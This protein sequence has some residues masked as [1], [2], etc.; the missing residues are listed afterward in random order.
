MVVS[1]QVCC[2]EEEEAGVVEEEAGVEEEEAGVVEEDWVEDWE[3][4]EAGDWGS[5]EWSL[6]KSLIRGI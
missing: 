3:E 2:C 1:S 4:E 5:I 6:R